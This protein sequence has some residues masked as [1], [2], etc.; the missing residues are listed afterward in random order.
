MGDHVATSEHYIE[1]TMNLGTI[2]KYIERMY[3]TKSAE[4]SEVSYN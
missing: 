4:R 2:P 3:Q 1:N